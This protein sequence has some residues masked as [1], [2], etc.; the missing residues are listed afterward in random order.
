MTGD[1]E[2]IISARPRDLGGFSVRRILPHATRRMVGPFIFFDH[3]GPADFNPGEGLDVRPHPHINLATVTYL[4]EGS[5]LHRDSL[6]SRQ[7]IEPGAINWMTAGRGIVHSERTPSEP[8]ATGSRLHGIQCWVA[9]PK[10]NEEIA[11][12]FHH[13]S[14][15]TLPE[16]VAGEAAV[17][18]LLGSAF[19][20]RS[21]VEVHS[22]LFYFEARLKAGASFALAADGRESA[23]YWVEGGGLVG[24]QEVRAGEMAVMCSGNGCLI[25]ATQ[26]SRL[27]AIGGCP[28]EGKREIF[29][30]F[31]SSSKERIERAKKDWRERRFPEIPDDNQEFIPLPDENASPSGKPPG[32]IL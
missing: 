29:W 21:P 5:I 19:G 12:S 17:K 13:H 25:K 6:G 28:L 11:P 20:R 3:M 9:L 7:V 1:I 15:A 18:L 22:D 4:F 16:F 26:S 24:H 23:I 31:V 27:M 10:E 2:Q 30:N 8:R 14:A 32:T